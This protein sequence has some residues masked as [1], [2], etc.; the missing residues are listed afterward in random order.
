MIIFSKIMLLFIVTHIKLK[1]S[2]FNHNDTKG[3]QNLYNRYRAVLKKCHLINTSG[4]LAVAAMLVMSG[5]ST[6]AAAQAT[7]LVLSEGIS[8][9]FSVSA[10][11]SANP[12]MHGHNIVTD[13]NTCPLLVAE[14]ITLS[15]S[16]GTGRIDES[17]YS[18][19]VNGT[20][21]CSGCKAV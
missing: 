12:E 10:G 17:L 20:G 1:T 14:N 13:N 21:V 5:A 3:Y 9:I 8:S 7:D 15:D 18:A 6:A 16:V 2:I 11:S 4:S 19:I